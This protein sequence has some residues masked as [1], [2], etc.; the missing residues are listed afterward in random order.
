[1]PQFVT[2]SALLEAQSEAA[3]AKPEAGKP[4]EEK[5]ATPNSITHN[6]DEQWRSR[7]RN[8]TEVS[9][10]GTRYKLFLQPVLVDPFTDTAD[11]TEPA[12]EWVLCGLKSVAAVEWEALSIS[13]TA[14]IWF[15]V[16]F[17]AIAMTGPLLKVRFMNRREHFRVQEVAAL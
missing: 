1:G 4:G 14:M 5:S 11:Q 7:S 12:R 3:A 9:L 17:L 10:A 16:L 8:L 2:L 15:T 13:Y 6:L